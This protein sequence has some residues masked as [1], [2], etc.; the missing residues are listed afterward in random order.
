MTSEEIELYQEEC[1]AQLRLLDIESWLLELSLALGY[2]QLE[3][4]IITNM[5][6]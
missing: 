4:I 6:D 3:S 5:T 2:P 1:F